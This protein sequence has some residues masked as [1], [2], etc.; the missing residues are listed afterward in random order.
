MVGVSG[1]CCG[2]GDGDFE[3]T[4][5]KQYA[6]GLSAPEL[7]LIHDVLCG[8]FQWRSKQDVEEIA[9]KI[10]HFMDRSGA[11]NELDPSDFGD[12]DWMKPDG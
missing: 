10:N 1:W 4:K 3:M 6:I 8:N 12:Y 11:W 7:E 2:A 9:K 5:T